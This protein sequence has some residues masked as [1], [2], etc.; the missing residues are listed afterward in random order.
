MGSTTPKQYLALC[1]QPVLRHTIRAL[2]ACTRITEIIVVINKH[3]QR[4]YDA[5]VAPLDD[6]RLQPPAFGS[7]TRSG[8][9]RNGLLAATGEYVAIH[10]AARPLVS[11]DAVDRVLD[12]ATKSGAAFLA[13][14]LTDA[15]W[16]V[17]HETAVT[18]L[19]RNTIWRAQTPQV[20]LRAD[21]T[22]AHAN[23]AGPA[24]DDV[25]VAVT[26]GLAVTPVIG[27]DTNIKL[28]VAADFALAMNY[29]DRHMDIRC[30]NGFDVHR[31]G[32]GDH[33]VLCGIKV[34]HSH[35][36]VGHSDADVAMHAV[37][38]A[39]FGAIAE[40]DIGQ[41]FPPSDPQ[42]KGVASDVFLRK[43]VERATL[44]GFIV[45]NIDVTLICELPK[46]GP[47]SLMMRDSLAT[48]I[49]I[50]PERVNVKA[51]TS[52]KLGFTGREEGIAAMAGATLMG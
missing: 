51:T 32:P 10:D 39:I 20:F 37:T 6:P 48:I 22:R 4:L 2:L 45:N 50:S 40:G 46:I 13:L 23:H 1:G 14:P 15:A 44:R 27:D 9:V 12:Q 8:S 18:A 35:G 24:D 49:G 38:D 28:T 31:F 11:V 34:P 16:Q 42:W 21:I 36:L 43:A 3:D 52:E 17:E 26:A 19:P 5:A 7:D 41:W 47:N 30:G 29:M 33:V 25:A